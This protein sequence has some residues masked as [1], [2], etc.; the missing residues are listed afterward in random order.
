MKAFATQ[1]SMVPI[2]WVLSHW[3]GQN[4]CESVLPDQQNLVERGNNDW[5]RSRGT[6]VRPALRRLGDPGQAANP[7]L[8]LAPGSRRGRLVPWPVQLQVELPALYEAVRVVVQ[9]RM[10]SPDPAW[11]IH[12]DGPQVKEAPGGMP[13]FSLRCP[14]Q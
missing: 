3:I 13:I 8:S 9:T 11:N 7:D 12:P 4:W 6:G 1:F 2:S 14:S 5:L 10:E